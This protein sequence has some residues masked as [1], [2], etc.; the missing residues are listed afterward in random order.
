M[1]TEQRA[2]FKI[3]PEYDQAIADSKS[4]RERRELFKDLQKTL[5]NRVLQE[6]DILFVTCNTAGSE[7]V[8]EGF[9]TIVLVIDETGS[10]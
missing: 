7:A 3:M 5:L 10:G 2:N 4:A 6:T 8:F 1:F 9:K